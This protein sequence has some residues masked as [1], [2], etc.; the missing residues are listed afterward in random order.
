MHNYTVVNKIG[1]ALT[2]TSQI[3]YDLISK[4]R[5]APIKRHG[6]RGRLGTFKV[7]FLQTLVQVTVHEILLV[8]LKDA[9]SSQ[10]KKKG[11]EYL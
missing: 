8:I 11:E 10:Q 6:K 5:V 7:Q 3:G 2:E 9:G 4:G 1:K